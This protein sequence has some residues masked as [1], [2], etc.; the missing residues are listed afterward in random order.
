MNITKHI[1]LAFVALI[2]TACVSEEDQALPPHNPVIFFE[3]FQG[4]PDN[5]F[6]ENAWTN[7]AT[8][9]TKTWFGTTHKGNG[10]FRFSPFGSN[11]TINEAWLI[12]PK[13]NI[14]KANAKKMIFLVA[15]NHVTDTT[16]NHIKL[17][18]SS[19]F[20]GDIENAHW[21]EKKF[22]HPQAQSTNFQFVNSGVVDLSE[23][24]GEINIGF[25]AVG[26]KD[27]NHSG[28]YQIDDIKIF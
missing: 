10:H 22:N 8:Q 28:G 9:G 24:S 23:F 7:I 11:E 2:F 17:Y 3:D 5:T 20:E 6:N 27:N 14:D 13:I 15:Q 16:N 26:G 18:I 19:N 12:T 25:K 4:I 1:L 21:V